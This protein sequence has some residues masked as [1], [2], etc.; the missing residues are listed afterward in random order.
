MSSLERTNVLVIEPD[1]SVQ[2]QIRRALPTTDLVFVADGKTAIAAVK[3]HEPEIILMDVALPSQDGYEILRQ[4]HLGES[5][6]EVLII[7]GESADPDKYGPDLETGVA[8][9]RFE[10]LERDVTRL[11]AKRAMQNSFREAFSRVLS[12][13][14]TGTKDLTREERR[15]LEGAGFPTDGAVETA[16]VAE[17]AARFQAIIA[18]SLTTEYAAKK[19][20]VNAS[21]VRQR[22]LAHPPQLY[23]IRQRNTWRLPAFQFGVKG[24]I[25]NIDKVIARLDPALD[26]VAVDTWFRK[27]SIDLEEHERCVSPL[28]WLAQGRSFQPVAELAEDL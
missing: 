14:A 12:D 23:G 7:T 19:L 28:D 25:P 5:T 15:A 6:S 24:L 4:L 9:K 18:S 8:K 21:R 11:L 3:R 26:P 17:R 13:A 10:T 1:K 27:P 2:K 20:R 22:L 16:P